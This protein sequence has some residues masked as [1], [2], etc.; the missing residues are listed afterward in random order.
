MCFVLSQEVY[1]F[2]K[3][4]FTTIYTVSKLVLITSSFGTNALFMPIKNSPPPHLFNE[5]YFPA[6]YNLSNICLP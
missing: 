3:E 4:T 5:I 1:H 6:M 2:L